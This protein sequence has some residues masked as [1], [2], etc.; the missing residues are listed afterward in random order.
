[1][2]PLPLAL[3]LL[4]ALSNLRLPLV[5]FDEGYAA[6]SAWRIHAGELPYR[7]FFANYG[8][9]SFC[10]N[11]ALFWLLGDKLAV[12]RVADLV[13][14]LGLALLCGLAARRSGS[15]GAWAFAAAA[16]FLCSFNGFGY[17]VMPALV[18]VLSGALAW[19]RSIRTG[20]RRWALWAGLG[21]GLAAGFR[22]DLGP[23]L[24][25]ALLGHAL[26]LR[27]WTGE[28]WALRAAAWAALAGL[29]SGCLF[30]L[31]F[32]AAAGW[33]R[34][35]ELLVRGTVAL[36]DGAYVLPVPAWD[37]PWRLG[38]GGE[39]AGE[40]TRAVVDQLQLWAAF[41]ISLFLLPVAGLAALWRLRRGQEEA[42]AVLLFVLLGGALLRQ[43]LNRADLAHVF[44]M[45]LMLLIVAGA[46]PRRAGWRWPVTAL[47]WT[48]LVTLLWAPLIRW[49]QYLGRQRDWPT[50]AEGPA[51]GL[52]VSPDLDAAA[53]FIA[54]ATPP[55]SR[56][57]VANADM[58][59]GIFSHVMFY[60]LAQRPCAS[61]YTLILRPM[62]KAAVADIEAALARPSTSAVV[63]WSGLGPERG[64]HPLDQALAGFGRAVG[65]VGDYEV[66]LRAPQAQAR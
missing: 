66:R 51:A 45:S 13:I 5:Y 64:S 61:F 59:R 38:P 50:A 19:L 16:V 8:P 63:I 42:A 6:Y 39:A 56:I 60:F 65:T 9:G 21:A 53:A 7:D 55:E 28:R 27:F 17:A 47:R 58:G 44:P 12:L 34:L 15:G 14:R 37:L 26:I 23:Y 57:F 22:Q 20:S 52:P 48:L 29:A 32:A 40:S 36:R 46:L 35:W 49:T 11:G 62:P 54:K 30:Y 31:P 1:M 43:A 24:G 4:F 3:A 18:L 33:A 41:W 10:A 25:A 2:G